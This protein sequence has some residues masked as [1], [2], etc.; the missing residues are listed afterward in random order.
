VKRRVLRAAL[1]LLLLSVVA[2]NAYAF[3]YAYG[4]THVRGGERT[5]TEY[6]AQWLGIP[7]SRP[8]SGKSPAQP[9]EERTI[10][11]ADG[12]G[13]SAWLLSAPE[14]RG[15]VV[16][17]H[18]F[19]GTRANLLDE[20]EALRTMGWSALLVALRGTETS[21][22]CTVSL[23]L[24]EAEDV[25]AAARSVQGGP[26][27]VYGESMGAAAS[28]HAVAT[29]HTPARA[30]ILEAPFARLSEAVH[31]HFH[32]KGRLDLTDLV[33][34]WGGIQQGDDPAS[35]NPEDEAPAVRVPVLTFVGGNDRTIPPATVRRLAARLPICT[36]EDIPGLGHCG[37]RAFAPDRWKRAVAALLERATP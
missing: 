29:L 37:T 33:L 22:G 30:L 35:F 12:T 5:A 2:V 9:Y 23:G 7:S 20:A 32:N 4:M 8:V 10:T 36:L 13:L 1:T 26:V 34:F 17:V 3:V 31:A 6:A 16:L 14:P 18:G 28:L 25:E 24:H 27:V 21:G 15:T 19:L 11:S